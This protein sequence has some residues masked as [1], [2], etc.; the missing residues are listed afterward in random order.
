MIHYPD[1]N[2]LVLQ[3]HINRALLGP[4]S[5]NRAVQSHV[6][7]RQVVVEIARICTHSARETRVAVPDAI[8]LF[9]H[10]AAP[11][12]RD[13]VDRVAEGKF[14][15]SIHPRVE[16]TRFLYKAEHG[17]MWKCNRT[18]MSIQILGNSFIWLKICLRHHITILNDRSISQ[19]VSPPSS[20]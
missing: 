10:V 4:V 19:L 18:K 11:R 8:V 15:V 6:G 3:K 1:R 2:I 12:E 16:Q 5:Q 17:M 20:A 13:T 9:V 14:R 7:V